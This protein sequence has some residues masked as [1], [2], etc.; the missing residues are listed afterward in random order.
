MVGRGAARL[1]SAQ[2]RT[3]ESW[4]C[5][6]CPNA[7]SKNL[8]C[9]CH[10]GSCISGVS[11]E[12]ADGGIPARKRAVSS[13]VA[14]SAAC[15]GAA[16]ARNMAAASAAIF[17]GCSIAIR[18]LRTG[19]RQLRLR[20]AQLDDAEHGEERAEQQRELDEIEHGLETAGEQHQVSYRDLEQ[21]GVGRRPVARFAGKYP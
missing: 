5:S 3:F 9:C 13:A 7:V 1:A 19:P 15:A 12:A 6:S 14:V 11:G 18:G 20:D 17:I 10:E 8:A 2:P 21:D 4:R 16:A